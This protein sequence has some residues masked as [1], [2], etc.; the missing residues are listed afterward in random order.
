MKGVVLD[1]HPGQGPKYLQLRDLEEYLHAKLQWDPDTDVDQMVREFCD[2]FYGS[3]AP[4]MV[5]VFHVMND[6]NSYTMA[7][8]SPPSLA[9][10]P[11]FHV[12]NG[13]ALTLEGMT[14]LHE[15]FEAAVKRVRDD[16]VRLKRVRQGRIFL[17]YNILSYA[18]QDGEMFAASVR[19]FSIAAGDV[20]VTAVTN[21]HL[22]G[23][24]KQGIDVFI[25]AMLKPGRNAE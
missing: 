12:E 14:R 18:P 10:F 3:A 20:G 1:N 21:M 11:G 13:A 6:D 17:Q 16:V 7:G 8:I 23:G 9:K 25:E 4:E 24:T 15:L 19:D 2:A 5:Q 22:H